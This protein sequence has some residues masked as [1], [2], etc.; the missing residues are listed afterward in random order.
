MAAVA[1]GISTIGLSITD[2]YCQRAGIA[3]PHGAHPLHLTGSSHPW[4]ESA[5]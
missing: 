1:L 3:T 5:A 2:P 4:G